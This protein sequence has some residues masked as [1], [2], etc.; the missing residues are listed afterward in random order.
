MK[1]GKRLQ[2][3]IYQPWKEYYIP[4]GKL[5]RLIARR[6]FILDEM[7]HESFKSNQRSPAQNQSKWHMELGPIP[8]KVMSTMVSNEQTPIVASTGPQ[9]YTDFNI[10]LTAKKSI[11]DSNIDEFFPIL[12]EELHKINTFFLG[13]L[14]EIRISVEDIVH[15]LKNAYRTHHTRDQHSDLIIL[16]DIYIELVHL[17]SYVELNHIG[18]YKIV[19][20][21]DKSFGESTLKNWMLT[22]NRQPFYTSNDPQIM[23]DT[24]TEIVSRDK[25]IEWE[26]FDSERQKMTDDELFPSVRVT[27]LLFSLLVFIVSLFL[28]IIPFADGPARRCLSLL[29]LSMSMWVTEAIPYYATAIMIPPL[30]VFMKVLKNDKT[31]NLLNVDESAEFVLSHM[32]NH[33]SMLLLG[34]Y[35]ISSA[36]SRCQLELRVAAWLQKRLGGQPRLFI[37]A[38]MFLGLFLSMWINNHTAPILLSTILLPIVR[39]LPTH[40]RFAKALL[41]GLAVACNFGGMMTPISSLQN[42][43]AVSYL[44]QNNS[45][46]TFDRWMCVSVP[47]CLTLT[48]ISWAAIIVIIRPDDINRIPVV[49]YELGNDFTKRDMTV[50]SVSVVTMLL[51]ATSSLTD[52]VFGDIGVISLCFACIMYGSG[53]LTEVDFNSL[54]WH[55]L[56]LVGGGGVLGKAVQ[57]SGLLTFIASGITSLLLRSSPWLAL[58]MILCF[59]CTVSTFV[60]HTVASIILMPVIA[61][62][63]TTLGMPQE[64]TIG[65]AFAVSAAMALPFSSFPNVN[66]LLIVDDFQRQYLTVKDF[67]IVGLP[68]S[69]LT[70]V[71][72]A[73]AGQGLIWLFCV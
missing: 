15:K 43:L 69:I 8:T 29:L 48:L 37:L 31:H 39:D 9:K 3:G 63:G 55:T 50:I 58:P 47:F 62:V 12:S 36:F 52:F 14:A 44:E 40:S 24:I 5:K 10:K 11:D 71:L 42:V 28:P 53:M 59:M 22:M 32:F 57:S 26:R 49:V 56:F 7:Q 20:K 38:I 35:T 16:R 60:S 19:K 66:S 61:N 73:T 4:Y 72:I 51:F 21:Y 33:T 46:V 1:F 70:L 65:A 30:V 68:L 18:F 25:L 64:V 27:G 67:V 17:K 23:I 34:G 13:K 45:G 54:S 41:L 2:N 6:R